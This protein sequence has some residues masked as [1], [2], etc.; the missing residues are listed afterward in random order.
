[1][2]KDKALLQL[3]GRSLLDRSLELARS[4]ADDVCIVGD[5]HKFSTYDSVVQ[6][7]FPGRGPLGGIHAA[8][9][10]S[11][12][13]WNLM[14][15][16]DLPF[17]ESRFLSHLIACARESA[18]MVIVPYGGGRW[19]PL[20]AIYRRRF[21]EIAEESLRKGENR[22]DAL[23]DRVQ[24]Q[25]IHE[26]D[27]LSMGFSTNMLR[28]LNTPAEWQAAEAELKAQGAENKQKSR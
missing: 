24:T 2:G 3:Q 10:Q 22:I 5:P 9:R 17:V 19:Q 8:L 15:A 6:D 16:V 14:L 23:L 4:V 27:I 26:E 25:I 28:N 11:Q 13:E 21:G 20:C 1:M 18:A 7:V 12:T